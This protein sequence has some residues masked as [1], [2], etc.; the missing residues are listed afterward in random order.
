MLVLEAAPAGAP[1]GSPAALNTRACAPRPF[2][3][4]ETVLEP[5][6]TLVS[7]PSSAGCRVPRRTVGAN[8]VAE[9]RALR[10]SADQ[11]RRSPTPAPRPTPP[12]TAADAD[13]PRTT[14]PR[15]PTHPSDP[16]APA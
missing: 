15:D 4:D 2:F 6:G 10:R 5:G 9:L 3:F 1:R 8:L 11:P 7:R 14:P 13:L 12:A 16:E